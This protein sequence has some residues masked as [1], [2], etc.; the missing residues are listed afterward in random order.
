M[1]PIIYASDRYKRFFAKSI[2]NIHNTRSLRI[3]TINNATIVIEPNTQRFG[4]FDAKG[5]IIKESLQLR[6][7]IVQQAPVFASEAEVL[8]IDA[9]YLG[10]LEDHFGHFL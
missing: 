7:K 10:T 9:V 1:N 4:V 8:D 2:N 5:N 3:R 6:N